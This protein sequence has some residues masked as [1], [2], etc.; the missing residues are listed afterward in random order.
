M[1]CEKR[2]AEGELK[3]IALLTASLS[4]TLRLLIERHQRLTKGVRAPVVPGFGT[5]AYVILSS[6]CGRSGRS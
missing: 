1:N 4:G 5:E 3:T 6:G 2:C